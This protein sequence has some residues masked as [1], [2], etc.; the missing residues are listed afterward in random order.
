VAL[1]HTAP[2]YEKFET[3]CSVLHN[4]N[5]EPVALSVHPVSDDEASDDKG[6]A[7]GD[8]PDDALSTKGNCKRQY[9]VVTNFNLQGLQDGATPPTIVEDKEDRLDNSQ[10][11]LLHWHH[12]LGHVSFQ[13]LRLMATKG[14][15]PK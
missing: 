14:A 4:S 13:K 15:M 5:D 12:K 6:S 1:F 3:F 10:S 9:P 7:E 8:D 2:N 11:D